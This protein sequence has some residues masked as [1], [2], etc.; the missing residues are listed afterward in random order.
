FRRN[1]PALFSL[2]VLVVMALLAL[3]APLLANNRPLFVKY[4]GEVFFPAF[5]LKK[6][7]IVKTDSGVEEINPD[8]LD[9]KQKNLDAVIWAP[10]PYAPGKADYLNSNF[11][12]PLGEQKF[13][14]D[15]KIIPMPSRFRH[16]LGT[17]SRG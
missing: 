6:T 14:K 10:V 16:W 15:G 17:G 12:R 13:L 2:Y 1:K 11:A 9:W 8:A 4:H 7:M 3:L 5:S